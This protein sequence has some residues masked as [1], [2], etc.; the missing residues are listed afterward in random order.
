MSI[1]VV[2]ADDHKMVREGLQ[3]ILNRAKGI[4]VVGEADN[5]RAAVELVESLAPDVVI[6]DVAMPEL[7]GMEA[8]RRIKA[9]NPQVKI[10][11]L[12]AY[13]DRAYVAGML[14]AGAIGYVLKSAAGD[15][16]VQAI[17]AVVANQKYL[18]ADIT[19]IGPE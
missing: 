3:L 16:L 7:N 4:E 10:I 18:S 19:S 5:G 6:M 9:G 17:H 2:L 1:R 8:A 13:Q 12:S 15:E 11:G 14:D